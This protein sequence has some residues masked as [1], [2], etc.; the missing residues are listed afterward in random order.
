MSPPR[1]F[2]TPCIGDFIILRWEPLKGIKSFN[3]N[4]S[5]PL[6]TLAQKQSYN[7]HR[8][9]MFL[10]SVRCIAPFYTI[11]NAWGDSNEATWK[12][13]RIAHALS[14]LR[15]R[16]WLELL[17]SCECFSEQKRQGSSALIEEQRTKMARWC[18]VSSFQ[19]HSIERRHWAKQTV[20]SLS[21]RWWV[22]LL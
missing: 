1:P 13:L 5:H 3:N 14:L 6:N 20:G 22:T 18:F 12:S 2:L 16:Y 4:Q 21:T 15:G 9:S 19:E 10:S 7:G 11:P 17:F 8:W